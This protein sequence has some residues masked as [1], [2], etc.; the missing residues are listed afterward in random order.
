MSIAGWV[1][2]ILNEEDAVAQAEASDSLV[3]IIAKNGRT[4]RVYATDVPRVT[5][6]VVLEAMG[7]HDVDAIVVVP[8]SSHYDWSAR[9]KA[10]AS[11]ST[12]LTF[13][14]LRGA[15][16]RE[17]LSSVLSRPVAYVRDAL[18]AHTRVVGVEML[19]ERSMRVVREVPLPDLTVA[20]DEQY[21][22]SAEA[23]VAAV[24]LHPDADIICD[25]N[26][27][28]RVTQAAVEQAE[29]AGVEVMKLR[30]LFSRLH[31]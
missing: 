9:L 18:E 30:D 15:I 16:G 12:V 5:E 22:F 21:E 26:P 1:A 4:S 27:N 20:V 28:G 31:L 11:G 24:R 25:N 17:D 29:H 13:G 6:D 3:E 19:C 8:R 14:E 7:T 10:E 2:R 23:V